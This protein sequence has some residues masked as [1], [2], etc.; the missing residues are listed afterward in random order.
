MLFFFGS[1]HFRLSTREISPIPKISSQL[2]KL[3]FRDWGFRRNGDIMKPRENYIQNWLYSHYDM[4]RC[5]LLLG[6][7]MAFGI[8]CDCDKMLWGAHHILPVGE[9]AIHP[10]SFNSPDR[11]LPLSGGCSV[12]F[13]RSLSALQERDYF[14]SYWWTPQ[15]PPL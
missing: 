5:T 2:N 3:L 12:Y 14:P 10:D 11:I 7:H 6:L 15:L 13:S 1:G 4:Q 9:V 8:C